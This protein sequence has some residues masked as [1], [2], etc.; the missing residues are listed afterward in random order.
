[1]EP[2]H[3]GGARRLVKVELELEFSLQ[4]NVKI[5]ENFPLRSKENLRAIIFQNSEED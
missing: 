5:Y 4:E 3:H 1:M 2:I